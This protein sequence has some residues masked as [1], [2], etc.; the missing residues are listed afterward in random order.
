MTFGKF[1]VLG[2]KGKNGRWDFEGSIIDSVYN[3]KKKYIIKSD[4]DILV[5]IRS[6]R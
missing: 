5:K 1:V 6:I 4:D 2:S 3:D